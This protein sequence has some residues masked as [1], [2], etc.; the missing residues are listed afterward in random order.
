MTPPT[1]SGASARRPRRRPWVCSLARTGGRRVPVCAMGQRA[2]QRRVPAEQSSPVAWLW[3]P[4]H[5]HPACTT[6]TG[7]RAPRPSSHHR[8]GPTPAPAHRSPGSTT[9]RGRAERSA[10]PARSNRRACR[11]SAC[12]SCRLRPSAGSCGEHP[13]CTGGG[14]RWENPGQSAGAIS[15]EDAHSG[16]VFAELDTRQDAAYTISLEWDRDTDNTRVV[17]AD[18]QTAW[19]LVLPVSGADA[20]DAFRHPFRYAP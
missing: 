13:G 7:K 5:H 8:R 20:G 14:S 2:R 10:A 9:P 6:R 3:L 18:R 15:H 1:L 12:A 19:L 16:W 11:P 4:E 17:V